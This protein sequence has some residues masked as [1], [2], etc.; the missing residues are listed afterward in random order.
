ML[1]RGCRRLARDENN[2]R[3]GSPFCTDFSYGTSINSLYLSIKCC[4]SS[5]SNTVAPPPL[6]LSLNKCTCG[7]RIFFCKPD[8]AL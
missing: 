6:K 1:E 5:I 8:T 3:V 2:A 7:R 4:S